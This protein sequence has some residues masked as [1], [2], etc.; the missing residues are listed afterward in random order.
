[1][2]GLVGS[3]CRTTA[4]K[5][6]QINVVPFSAFI[7]LTVL[8]FTI[9]HR[10]RLTTS[11]LVNDY[12]LTHVASS[13]DFIQCHSQAK[14]MVCWQNDWHAIAWQEISHIRQQYV[15]C[16]WVGLG[17]VGGLTISCAIT[18]KYCSCEK[19]PYILPPT[20]IWLILLPATRHRRW[21]RG[22]CVCGLKESQQ[23]CMWDHT[24]FTL[25]QSFKQSQG[26]G[27][28][29]V[30][31]EKEQSKTPTCLNEQVKHTIPCYLILI[32][33]LKPKDKIINTD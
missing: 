23:C 17:W 21:V 26:P 10:D 9:Q 8:S 18:I 4:C 31:M 19:V 27:C 25:G 15:K 16:L 12:Q 32:L 6:C 1:M 30:N 3:I 33:R 28:R 14:L 13:S 5:L 22:D 11:Q 7:V 20:M 2:R 24:E 29:W